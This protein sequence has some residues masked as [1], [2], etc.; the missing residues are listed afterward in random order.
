MGTVCKLENYLISPKQWKS[1]YDDMPKECKEV[2]NSLP[3]CIGI[4]RNN[5]IGWFIMGSGQGPYLLWQEKGHV[6]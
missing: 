2:V 6:R 3:D 4:G 1:Q 5:K